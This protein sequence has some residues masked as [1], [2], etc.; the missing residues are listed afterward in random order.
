MDWLKHG[1]YVPEDAEVLVVDGVSAP[2]AA[3]EL[4]DRRQKLFLCLSPGKHIVRFKREGRPRSVSITRRFLDS[5]EQAAG[6]LSRNGELD[7]ELLVRQSLACLER[8]DSPLIPHLWGNYYWQRGE[9]DAARRHYAWALNI[10]P[11]FAPSLFNLGVL[12]KKQGEER[13]GA[14]LLALAKVWNWQDGYGLASLLCDYPTIRPTRD[15]SVRLDVMVSP[16]AKTLTKQDSDV[17]AILTTSAAFVPDESEGIKLINNIGAYFEHVGKY[18]VA[19]EY[20]RKAL[21]QASGRSE[22][23]SLVLPVLRN[24]AR[25]AMKGAMPESRRYARMVEILSLQSKQADR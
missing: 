3:L 22:T 12:A 2:R 17:V 13:E 16:W 10:M 7:F 23:R 15:F 20:Y 9:F 1:V 6:A 4:L 14:E 11:N 25:A 5:Y 19:I 18:E 21:N 24:L 8:F